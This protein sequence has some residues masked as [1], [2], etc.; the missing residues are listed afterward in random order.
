MKSTQMIVRL[1]I[2]LLSMSGIFA[3]A[4]LAESLNDGLGPQSTQAIGEKNVLT[5]VVRFPDATPSLP[6]E[7]VRRKVVGGLNAYVKEQSYGRAS[8]KADFMGYVMLPDSIASYNIS[9]YN[10]R[11]DRRR[12]R[13]LI[14]DTMTALESRVDFSAYD[15][16]LIVPAVTTMPGKGYGMICYCANPGM[17]SGVTR[18]YVP[19]YETL[20]SSGG[21]EFKGGIFV[22]TENANIGMFAHDYF[23]ALGGIHEGKRLVP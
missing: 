4:I 10:F 18:R 7:A 15:H 14:E 3:G 2:I 22:A 17:L 12:V 1:T 20:R 9:P 21:K 8:I 5:V 6:I 19:R 13:K 11:V 16:I 23:H